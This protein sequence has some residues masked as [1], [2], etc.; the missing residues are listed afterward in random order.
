M[1]LK[2][3]A[4]ERIFSAEEVGPLGYSPVLPDGF[5]GLGILEMPWVRGK[6]PLAFFLSLL[7]PGPRSL[8]VCG[9][10]WDRTGWEE[11]GAWSR[12]TRDPRR[13]HPLALFSGKKSRF[14][15]SAPLQKGRQF[16]IVFQL[17]KPEAL[18]GPCSRKK[19]ER[20]GEKEHMREQWT[21]QV[22]GTSTVEYRPH[23]APGN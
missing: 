18:H 3:E 10:V 5:P 23:S 1:I 22:S 7:L 12:R 15:L 2:A 21:S 11:R 19:E 6:G 20:G 9:I 16:L 8:G 4:D 14:C 17:L 13:T